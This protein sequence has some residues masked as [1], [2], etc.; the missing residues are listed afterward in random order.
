M[1]SV[2]KGNLL[3]FVGNLTEIITKGEGISSPAGEEETEIIKDPREKI[4]RKMLL[5]ISARI[6]IGNSDGILIPVGIQFFN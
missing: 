2:F 6:L 5:E 4:L 1:I 3:V